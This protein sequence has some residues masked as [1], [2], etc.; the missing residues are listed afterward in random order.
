MGLGD[1][2]RK[3]GRKSVV[4][5]NWWQTAQHGRWKVTCVPVQHWSQ[6][7]EYWQNSTLWCGWVISSGERTYF[8]A[9]DTGY[10]HGFTEIGKR[11]AD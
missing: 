3:K 5:L 2:F 8:Y 10:F 6:R 9:G 4:E 7:I 1:W 11:F